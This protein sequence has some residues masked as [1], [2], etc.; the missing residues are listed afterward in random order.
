VRIYPNPANDF[1]K[2]DL[3]TS[4]QFTYE[5]LDA[6]GRTLMTSLHPLSGILQ[7]E[8]KDLAA[9]AYILKLNSDKQAKSFKIQVTN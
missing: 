3:G 8:V 7:L 1:I 9:G 2:V 4:N 5:V 6:S